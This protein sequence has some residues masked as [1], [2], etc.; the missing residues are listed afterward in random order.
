MHAHTHTHTRRPTSFTLDSELLNISKRW[1]V[2]GQIPG[3]DMV[4]AISVAHRYV[5]HYVA[6]DQNM[7]V[8]SIR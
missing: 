1:P 6:V 2:I 3:H 8:V 4:T 5:V 7:S